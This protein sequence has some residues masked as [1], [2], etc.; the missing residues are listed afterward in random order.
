VENEAGGFDPLRVPIEL[1]I[2]FLWEKIDL[3]KETERRLSQKE[4]PEDHQL[5]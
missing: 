3:G 1:S 2:H 4:K 5:V